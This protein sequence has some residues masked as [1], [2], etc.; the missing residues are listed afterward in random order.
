MEGKDDDEMPS[1]S[2]LQPYPDD[3]EELVNHAYEETCTPNLSA[4]LAQDTP[5]SD[6][7]I[8]RWLH[9]VDYKLT[10]DLHAG[11]ATSKNGVAAQDH[12]A[13]VPEGGEVIYHENEAK[14]T[15]SP[16]YIKVEKALIGLISPMARLNFAKV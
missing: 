15:K 9:D 10:G 5:Q 3:N 12:A 14:L 4:E 7:A 8:A 6:S 11:Q 1:S 13:V 16:M 2:V